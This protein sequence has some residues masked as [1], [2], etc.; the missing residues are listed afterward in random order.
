MGFNQKKTTP[1]I[2]PSFVVCV[3]SPA[4]AST[5]HQQIKNDAL[6]R[7]PLSTR[8]DCFGQTCKIKTPFIRAAL[9]RRYD[10]FS[11]ACKITPTLSSG[12]RCLLDTSASTRPPTERQRIKTTASLGSP[13]LLGAKVPSKI[14][15]SVSRV[16]V[17]VS[18]TKKC[19]IPTNEDTSHR[20][21]RYS[22][23]ID[24][25]KQR[26]TGTSWNGRRQTSISHAAGK[27]YC[28]WATRLL[29]RPRN[30]DWK[31]LPLLSWL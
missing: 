20:S 23:P 19:L 7:I 15:K 26:L 27:Q 17:G 2:K 11:Q 13:C 22:T 8:H 9:S 5:Q 1:F 14:F 4:T 28:V 25:M 16:K 3:T 30:Q 18:R 10:G 31:F 29:A 21:K 24:A 12:I 6:I